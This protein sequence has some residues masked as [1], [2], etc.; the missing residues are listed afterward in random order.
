MKKVNA[1]KKWPITFLIKNKNY[2]EIKHLLTIS[3]EM[4]FLNF[5]KSKKKLFIQRSVPPKAFSFELDYFQ[6]ISIKCIVKKEN[7]LIAAHTSSGKTV[8]AEYTIANAFCEK[9]K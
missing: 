6:K 4:N 8:I 2:Q 5:L 9:K 7:I 3:G 1:L